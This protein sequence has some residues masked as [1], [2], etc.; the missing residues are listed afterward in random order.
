VYGRSR[1]I[2]DGN[3]LVAS[4]ARLARSTPRRVRRVTPSA[5]LARPVAGVRSAIRTPIRSQAAA[6]PQASRAGWIM[7]VP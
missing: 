6:S 5:S 7:A 2:S 1:L 4:T 3:A